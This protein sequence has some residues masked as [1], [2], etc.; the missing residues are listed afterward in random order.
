MSRVQ[1][2]ANITANATVLVQALRFSVKGYFPVIQ[3]QTVR[4]ALTTGLV[5]W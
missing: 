4:A 2:T 5:T 3:S 1:H